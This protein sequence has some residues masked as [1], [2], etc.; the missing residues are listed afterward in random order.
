[1]FIS[2]DI[3]GIY[4]EEFNEK[5]VS[6]LAKKFY[7][8]L[9]KRKIKNEIFLG[10]DLRK[11][12]INLANAFANSYLKLPKTKIE[13]LGILPSPI[14]YHKC[15]K[16]RKAGAM[17]TASHLP[18]KFNGIKF[19]LP[20]GESWVYKGKIL[21]Q[22]V[23]VKKGIKYKDVV[24]K[25]F[26]KEYILDIQKF[27]KLEKKHHLDFGNKNRSVNHFLFKT[28][29]KYEKK[30]KV[31]KISPLKIISDFDGDRLWIQYKD[32]N[33]LPEQILFAILKS[34]YYKKI[35]VPL[36]MSKKILDIFRNLNLIFIPTGHSN[37]KRAFKKYKLDFAFEPSFHYYFFKETKTESPL[38]GLLRFL[39]YIE[40]F[41]L[42]EIFKTE[43][44]VKRFALKRKIDLGKIVNKLKKEGFKM[45]KFD[46]FNFR[47]YI[48]GDYFV[49]HI[50]ESK[51][52]ENVYRFFLESSS[53]NSLKFL[54]KLVK[55]IIK[56]GTD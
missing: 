49:V 47:K 19:F 34:G 30:I 41:S 39:E 35:G 13:Y 32:T 37:F 2:Y 3:R 43:F 17:I 5:V 23:R 29:V 16:E 36:N 10:I 44:Y 31:K 46:G 48:N 54:N 25:N 28:L 55:R 1:M 45:K 7:Q 50:R 26:Y 53:K 14:F 51:T 22:D 9:E 56:N 40:K 12:S 8:F 52:E 6:F 24:F 11:S 21:F 20:N 15:L 42:N 18:L 4:P 38:L 33:L 27:Y